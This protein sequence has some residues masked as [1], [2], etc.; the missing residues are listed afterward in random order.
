MLV[1]SLC[2][3]TYAVELA[4][5]RLVP[6]APGFA[7][8][9]VNT[10]IFRHN[11]LTTRHNVQ[12]TAYYDND[13][14]VVLAK[15]KFGEANWTIRRTELI[16][17][18]YDAHNAIVLAAD[19]SDTLHI[20]W[21]HHNSELNYVRTTGLGSLEVTGR[22]K[23]DG[24]LESS[25][26]YPEMCSLP[27]GSVVLVYR[28]GTSGNGDIVMKRFR[29]KERKWTTVQ[30]RLIAGEGRHSAYV[31]FCID[32]HGTLH[33]AWTWRRTGNVATNHDI[34][35]ARSS[36]RGQTWTDSND[37]PISLP[38]TSDNAEYA[39]R[40]PE[41]SDLINQTSIAAD[42]A[43]HPYIAT[44]FRPV[45]QQAVQ[46]ML[47]HHDGRKWSSHQIGDRHSSFHLAGLGTRPLLISRPLVLLDTRAA[48][49]RIL[50][51]YRDV[52]R[53]NRIT[54]ASCTDLAKGDWSFADLTNDSYS[55]WEPTCDLS[56]WSRDHLLHL[57]VQ[58]TTQLEGDAAPAGPKIPPMPVSILEVLP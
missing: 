26:T 37:E 54:L 13:A 34:C 36:D 11:S 50:I 57:F 35:Y 51:V 41:N 24:I 29:S 17:N 27:D 53:Q 52:E 47:V 20:M 30:P 32:S 49:P 55:A 6:I 44:Y 23:T 45:G 4:P 1:C 19:A 15:R 46:L 9:S 38:I 2:G 3:A 5:A 43:G 58:K 18:P 31:E 16:G 42:D 12:F 39:L 28:S 22:Q 21:N 56:L 10:T 25:V 14:H 33:F 7:A 8:T 48:P 40:I